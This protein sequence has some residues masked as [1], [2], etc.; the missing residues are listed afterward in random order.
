MTATPTDRTAK[1]QRFPVPR[2]DPIYPLWP[3]IRGETVK[4]IHLNNFLI[5]CFRYGNGNTADSNRTAV[6]IC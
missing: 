4:R 6:V 2:S 1:V 5:N 3:K